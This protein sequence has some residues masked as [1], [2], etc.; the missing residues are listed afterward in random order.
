VIDGLIQWIST[1]LP[2]NFIL[3]KLWVP[4]SI[5]LISSKSVYENEAISGEV[6]FLNRSR[7]SLCESLSSVIFESGS[8]LSLIDKWTFCETGLVEI[9]IPS[10]V[11]V[12]DEYCFYACKS[13]PSVQFE[14]FD[15]VT[16]WTVCIQLDWFD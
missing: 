9:I 12:L 2:S 11:E 15:I 16:N 8:K 5:K 3:D 7:F 14:W 1:I 6:A 10:S 4:S 13:L